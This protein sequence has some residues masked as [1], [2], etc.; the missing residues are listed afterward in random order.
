MSE[1]VTVEITRGPLVESRHLVDVYARYIVGWRVS[2]S[3]Q[4]DFVLDALEQAL[5]CW[6]RPETEPLLKAVPA[7]TGWS[8]CPCE[9]CRVTMSMSMEYIGMR[10]HR[11]NITSIASS[12]PPARRLHD[13]PIHD[14]R[15]ARR[16]RRCRWSGRWALGGALLRQRDAGGG[17]AGLAAAAAVGA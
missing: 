2:S 12:P 14:L 13:L 4:A 1:P 9:R 5:Y 17:G 8:R 10:I 6:R 11:I 15:P 3:M 7:L 16:R